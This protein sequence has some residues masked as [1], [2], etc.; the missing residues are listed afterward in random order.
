MNSTEL[1]TAVRASSSIGD[2]L[3]YPEY[4]A[5]RILNE[6]NDKLQTAFE[7][8]VVSARAGYWVHDIAFTTTIGKNRYRIPNR[9][10]VG[11]LEKVEI[12][13]AIG[14]PF[15]KLDEV[16]ISI[17]QNYE[18]NPG[19][20]GTPVVYCVFGDQVELIPTPNVVMPIRLT[21][22]IRPSRLVTQ[23]STTIGGG[24][25]RGTVQS[26]NV[27]GRIVVIDILPFDMSLAVPVAIT[28]AVQRVDIVHANGWHEL[29]LV[30]ATQTIGGVGPFS[31]TIGGTDDLGDI[32]PGDFMRVADQTDWP[33]LPDDFHRCLADTTAVK[34]LLE[35]HLTEKAGALAENN[36]NDIVRFKSLLEPR[37][38]AEPKQVG[39]MRRS[40]GGFGGWPGRVWG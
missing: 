23:Q 17:A 10:V 40:R 20:Q 16:P 21:Y 6:L 1:D 3:Q 13:T 24:V 37:V 39:I 9:A 27:P 15:F 30:G 14:G 32:E 38:K 8:I 28:T 34:L 19:R 36:G 22:Y 26:V 5:A 7:D 25:V 12:A 33:C 2:A 11:G 18:G 4:S 35:Q 29:S 31:I